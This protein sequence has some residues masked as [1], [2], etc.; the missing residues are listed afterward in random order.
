MARPRYLLD[1]AVLAEL[2]R[3]AGNRLVLTRFRQ[4]QH[5]CALA[6]I[7]AYAL[8]RGV[9]S[10]PEGAR[11]SQLDAFVQELLRSGPPVLAFDLE[12]ARWLAR[13]TARRQRQYRSWSALEGQ[14]AATAAVHELH[15]VT[16]NP[17]AYAGAEA[18]VTQDWFRP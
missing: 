12:A 1:L 13:E 2:T 17:A 11:R 6:A 7:T 10:L 18:L 9:Q 5:D 14:Q 16:R 4:H 15:L 3:P 8:L